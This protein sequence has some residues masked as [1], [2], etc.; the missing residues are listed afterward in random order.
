MREMHS[1]KP[2][3]FALASLAALTALSSCATMNEDQCNVA[4]WRIMGQSDGSR[5]LAQT[6]VAR[7]QEACGK[8]GIAVDAT[9]WQSGWE[10]GIR[11]HCTFENGMTIGKEGRTATNACPIDMASD[12]T[13]AYTAGRA[14]YNADNRVDRAQRALDMAITAISEATE[15]TARQTARIDLERARTELASAQLEAERARGDL[16]RLLL[17]RRTQ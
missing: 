11:R 2:V 9:A 13:S 17:T 4:D 16:E 1:I 12:Y 3:I 8:F 7:H 6:H 15:D 5:G 10:E 14:V